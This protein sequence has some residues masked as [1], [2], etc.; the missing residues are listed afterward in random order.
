MEPPPPLAIEGT[1]PYF[2]TSGQSA[3]VTRSK[4]WMPTL[5]ACRQQS[6]RGTPR[7][8][9][10]RVTPC[11]RRPLRIGAGGAGCC[12]PAR[13]FPATASAAAVVPR[14]A[15]RFIGVAS[16]CGAT[17]LR[18]QD[19]CDQSRAGAGDHILQAI[20]LVSDRAVGHRVANA[21]VPERL[22]GRG[23]VGPDP[24]GRRVEQHVACRRENAR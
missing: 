1:R 6:S 4:P 8:N 16:L 7:P 18:I 12:C 22:A 20:E 3:G 11:L 19:E 23:V 2:F 5:A 17:P 14:N 24:G 21:R 13:A 10:P 15:R 9:T